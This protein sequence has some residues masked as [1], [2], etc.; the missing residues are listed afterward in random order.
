MTRDDKISWLLLLIAAVMNVA[1]VFAFYEMGYI[2]LFLVLLCLGV[3]VLLPIVL[4]V[5][6]FCRI[7]KRKE[8][9]KAKTELFSCVMVFLLPIIY[10]GVVEPLINRQVFFFELPDGTEMT[11]WKDY[12]VFEHYGN[13][14]APKDNYIYMGEY[15]E[16][17]AVSIS[18]DGEMRVW[19]RDNADKIEVCNPRFPLV[20]IYEGWNNGGRFWFNKE[21]PITSTYVNLA[22]DYYHDGISSGGDYYYDIVRADS[23]EHHL[24]YFPARLYCQFDEYKDSPWVSAIDS[25]AR[26][27]SA[28]MA[29]D[30]K[31]FHYQDSVQHSQLSVSYPQKG[32][33]LWKKS[34]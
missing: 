33:N 24:W 13:Y 27:D 28:S 10:F 16:H 9:R 2:A 15:Q 20:G 8:W 21:T 6:A 22:Y 23:V 25:I 30:M 5:W 11:V 18:N 7:V 4:V 14:R 19:M 17:Y 34:E 1:L 32:R 26:R 31:L 12:I 29:E 3:P